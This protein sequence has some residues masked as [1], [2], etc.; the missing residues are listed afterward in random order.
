M[1]CARKLWAAALAAAGGV[2][3]SALLVSSGPARA[4][5]GTLPPDG[6]GSP[7]PVTPVPAPPVL[8]PPV[9]APPMGQPDSL[10]VTVRESGSSPALSWSLTCNPDGGTHP[11][12]VLACDTLSGT[13]NPFAPVAP[14]TMC[15]MIYYGP[16]TATI[17]GYWQ[18]Q[19][20]SAQFSRVDGCQ[21]QRWE[22][23]APVLVIPVL[24][25]PANPGGPFLPG[26]VVSVALLPAGNPG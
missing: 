10:L 24:P 15:P 1:S 20:V 11:D 4:L 19:P 26:P 12:P 5:A 7:V 2:A 8:P 22:K 9:P 13:R 14:G 17:S 18:G 21:E 6:T 3:L 16:Q 23:I 25:V